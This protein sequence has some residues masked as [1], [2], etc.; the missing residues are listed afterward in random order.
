MKTVL[1][2]ID[3]IDDAKH[4]FRGN[5]LGLLSAASGVSKKGDP[6]YEIFH[7]KFN[8]CALY[9]PEHGIRS[10]LQEGIGMDDC[11]DEDTG[12]PLFNVFNPGAIDGEKLD[13]M[14]AGIDMLVYDIQDV[15]VRF[16]A[17]MYN[18]SDMMTRCA[19]LK[20]PVVVLDRINP[21]GGTLFEGP[22]LDEKNF[23]SEIGRYNLPARY[24]MTIGEYAKWVNVE[25][26]INCELYVIELKGW[27]RSLYAD[28]TD[29]LF[30]NPSPNIP[31]VN[32][33][34]NY[35]GTC[36]FEATNVSEGR[37]TTRPFDMIGAPY[38]NSKALV[39]HLRSKHIDGLTVRRA[40]FTPTHQKYAGQVCEGVE[41]HI[42]DRNVYRPLY[43]SLCIIEHMRTYQ[44]FEIKPD[45]L[46]KLYGTNDINGAFSPEGLIAKSQAELETYKREIQPYLLY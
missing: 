25:K 23:A 10:N 40:A 12:L 26:K 6:T 39:E 13:K 27:E 4:I 2:G 15:G 42:T 17:Y 46:A 8:L 3:R 33:A 19:I 31:A 16:Y 20:K 14:L 37:G 1:N 35:N 28:E 21:I 29:L 22:R 5:R 41:L 7:E 44:E 32:S 38:V 11:K 30:V 9:A 18:L 45:R 36:L 34:I 43:T 24:G